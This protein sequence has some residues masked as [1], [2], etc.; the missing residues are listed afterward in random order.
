MHSEV[1]GVA[2]MVK[3]RHYKNFVSVVNNTAAAIWTT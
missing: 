2:V 1:Y 3:G